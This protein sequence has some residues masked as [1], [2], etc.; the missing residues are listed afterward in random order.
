[1]LKTMCQSYLCPFSISKQEIDPEANIKMAMDEYSYVRENYL[2][3]KLSG[4]ICRNRQTLR[5][6]LWLHCLPPLPGRLHSISLLFLSSD[7]RQQINEKCLQPGIPTQQQ[8]LP[9]YTKAGSIGGIST[10][11]RCCLREAGNN[12]P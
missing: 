1:M 12:R 3:Y 5:I 8:H 9:H 2:F 7:R 11:A 6:F 4:L 10:Q